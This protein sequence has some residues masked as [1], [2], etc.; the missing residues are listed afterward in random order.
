[1]VFM[2]LT[3]LLTNIVLKGR[4]GTE[5]Q[6]RNIALELLRRG[7]RPIVYSPELGPI[8]DE[9]RRA[10]V[11]VVDDINKIQ[12]SIDIIHGHHTPT[13]ATAVTRFSHTPAIFVSH[14]FT[15]WHDVPPHLPAIRRYVAVDETVADRLRIEC[16]IPAEQL[17]I[18]LNQPDIERF[19]CGSAL[20]QQPRRALAFAKN[21]GHLDA[22]KQACAQRQIRLDV[23]GAEAG[24][25]VHD[26]EQLVPQ[27]DLIFASALTAMEA[28][29]CGRAVIVCDGR[30][31][32]GFVDSERFLRWRRLN[33]GLRTLGSPLN[34]D[35]IGAEIDRYDAGQ[36]QRVCELLRGEGGMQSYGEELTELYR[37]VIAEHAAAPPALDAAARALAVYL[38]KWSPLYDSRW[39]WMMERKALLDIIQ[40][41]RWPVETLAVGAQAHFSR[42]QEQHWARAVGGFSWP[43]AWGVWT[44]G[45]SATLF[46]RVD[47]QQK[48]QIVLRFTVNAFVHPLHPRLDVNILANGA[49]SE[50]WIFK[51]QHTR[52]HERV[53]TI[54]S[55]LLFNAGELWLYFSIKSPISPSELGINPDTRRLGLG[56]HTIELCGR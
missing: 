30:G 16:S 37:Q 54:A 53:L 2:P 33:F 6:T 9:L 31:L 48:S 4:S 51:E 19:R 23:V 35:A 27:Y 45:S 12:C 13:T 15:A 29:A 38:Q 44:D 34:V 56:F 50:T 49:P 24:R 26:P 21:A 52:E 42:L 14:D 20:P 41:L 1:M 46:L 10:S 3:I 18:L 25:I 55:D 5:I 39:P 40:Q 7:H 36:A 47:A 11:P 28:M 43:E 8:A 22:I 17:Q 32:A